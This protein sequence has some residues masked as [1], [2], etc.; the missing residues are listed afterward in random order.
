MNTYNDPQILTRNAL[1][2]FL[3]TDR[4]ALRKEIL[5]PRLF[6]DDVW[7]FQRLLRTAE[8]LS[9]CLD[10]WSRMR[11]YLVR[12]A[13]KQAGFKLGF[14]IPLHVFGAGLS[15]AHPGTI[16]VNTLTK[17]G[18]NCRI[19]ACV[20]IGTTG[21]SLK[22]PQIGHNVYIGPGA[23]IIGDIVLGDNLVIGANAVVVHSFPE[24]NCTIG[25]IP[26]KVISP[27]DS[28]E[29]LVKATQIVS[30]KIHEI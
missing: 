23:K 19:H 3:E 22:A 29:H 4:I 15:I 7:K 11:L 30:R 5:K 14:S 13:L 28:T 9:T 18:E 2:Y 20:N 17:V 10:P 26:A 25:G 12:W 16:V 24:G 8:Y 21:G 6:G 1:E 27:R